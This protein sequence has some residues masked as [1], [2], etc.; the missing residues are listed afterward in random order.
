MFLRVLRRVLRIIL[1]EIFFHVESD[2]HR[3]LG[4]FFFGNIILEGHHPVFLRDTAAVPVIILMEGAARIPHI[5]KA[6]EVAAFIQGDIPAVCLIV[7]V[8][9]QMLRHLHGVQLVDIIPAQ[10]VVILDTWVHVVAIQVLR[11]VDDLLDAAGMVADL[12]GRLELLIL[13]PVH[14]IQLRRQIV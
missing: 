1:P 4:Q 12:H 2:I 13:A 14:F 3:P 9:P 10:V 5:S 11:Q 8:I 6:G 7:D